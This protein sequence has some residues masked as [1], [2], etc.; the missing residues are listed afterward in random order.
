MI[1]TPSGDRP[2]ESLQ[3]GDAIWSVGENGER[4]QGKIAKA[5]RDVSNGYY[6]LNGSTRVTGAHRFMT[7]RSGENPDVVS[8][9][10]EQHALGEWTPVRDL[11]PGQQLRTIDGGFETVKTIEFVDRGVRV[12]NF[13]VEPYHNY[14]ANGVLVH[15]RKPDPSE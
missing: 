4:V 8:T 15:N 11:V 5:I 3:V 6:R 1:S 7:A 10:Y 14:F 2:I 13:E 9:K 12:F